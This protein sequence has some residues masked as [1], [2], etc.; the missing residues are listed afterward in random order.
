[1]NAPIANVIE[2]DPPLRPTAGGQVR[3]SSNT[4]IPTDFHLVDTTMM[5]GPRSGGVRRYLV[6]KQAW[7]AKSLPGV[8][9]TLVVPGSS[10]GICAPGTMTISAMPMPFSD[11]YRM[12]TSPWRWADAIRQLEPSLIEVGDMF[13][14]GYGS[15]AAGAALGVP[16]VGFCHTDPAMLAMRHFGRWAERPTRELWAATFRRFDHVIAPSRYMAARLEHAGVDNVSIQPLGVNTDT[17]HP[18]RAD[19]GGLRG[20]LGLPLSTRLLIFAGRPAREKNI[21]SMISAVQRLGPPYHLILVG[22]G[23]SIVESTQVSCLDFENNS[24]SLAR[25]LA[26]ADAFLHANDRE[27][28]GLSI[29]EAMAAGTPVICTAAGGAS[30]LVDDYVGQVATSASPTDL[31][32]AIEALFTRDLDVLSARARRRVE[33]HYDWNDS[34]D[35]IVQ[36]YI[37]L[38]SRS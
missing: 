14:P 26:S 13:V 15:L 28:F 36:I 20:E 19:K 7:L 1:M 24:L 22:A 17:F 37:Q 4:V 8:R 9:H 21:S 23:K 38:L 10:T 32:E 3:L 33:K 27:I 18:C 11:G 29:L 30:E 16:V 35:R 12:P 25:L 5:Y 34:F 31:S 6:E 2:I